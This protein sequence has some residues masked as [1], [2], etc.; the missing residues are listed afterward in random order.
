MIGIKRMDTPSN[1]QEA[2]AAAQGGGIYLAG[3]TDVLPELRDGKYPDAALVDLTKIKRDFSY[4]KR[5]PD[6]LRIGGL[7][8]LEHIHRDR[9]VLAGI[10]ALAKAAGQVGSLQIRNR[11][12]IAGNLVHASPAADTAPVLVAAGARVVLAGQAGER[13]ML[14]EEFLTG[15]GKTALVSGELLTEVI[16]P[17]NKT[18]WKGDYCK[19]GGR[20]SLTIAIASV[21]VLFHPD[22][23]YRVAYGS[24]NPCVKRAPKVEQALAADGKGLDEAVSA[25][26]NP[27][28]DVRASAWYRRQV[29]IDLTR[30]AWEEVQ[31]N[32]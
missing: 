24:V 19:L 32:G 7:T 23:G 11:G 16:V 26:I 1:L 12:T 3:G 20:T 25:S 31:Q 18:P 10:P 5:Q 6:C 27:I 8:N 28:D 30:L 22:A 15:P 13:E 17:L 29:C 14:L 9:D 2:L 4:I 21:A